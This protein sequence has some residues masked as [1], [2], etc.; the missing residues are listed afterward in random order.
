MALNNYAN[1]KASIRNWSKRKDATDSMI[2]DFIALA[3]EEFYSNEVSP[4]RTK[5]MDTRA[6]ATVSTSSR[7]LELPTNFLE[8]SRFKINAQTASTPGFVNDVD[9]VYRAPD[10]LLLSST[11]AH[12]GFFTVTSQLEFERIPDRAY[13]VDMQFYQKPTA[14]SSSNTTNSTLT[15]FPSIY[16]N[17]ALWAL[18]DYFREPAEAD[19]YRNIMLTAIRGA[20]K[21]NNK[22][23]YGNSPQ[24]K[25]ERNGP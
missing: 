13:V 25:K 12:P 14:L 8:M 4:L 17:G 5:E 20:N 19:R 11:T 1:L 7:F 3:E 9:I 15:N 23:R 18:W 22:I 16:L 10:Q 21:L 24:I 2:E 6:T